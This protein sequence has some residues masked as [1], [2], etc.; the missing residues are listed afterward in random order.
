MQSSRRGRTLDLSLLDV[1]QAE[2][3]GAVVVGAAKVHGA[4]V[5]ERDQVLAGRVR[6]GVLVEEL[7]GFAQDGWL[8][9]DAGAAL[10]ETVPPQPCYVLVMFL[11]GAVTPSTARGEC[12]PA[13]HRC[14]TNTAPLAAQ[15]PSSHLKSQ[16]QVHS[17]SER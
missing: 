13:P 15:K 9:Q 2:V 7:V 16:R 6:P 4:Q 3:V 5:A 12:F 11:K 17:L 8:R 10:R 14:I 1:E